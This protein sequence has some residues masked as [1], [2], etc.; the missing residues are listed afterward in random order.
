MP[1]LTW[2]TD[3]LSKE[4]HISEVDIIC[5]RMGRLKTDEGPIVSTPPAVP[6]SATARRCLESTSEEPESAPVVRRGR[7]PRKNA[8]GQD[9]EASVKAAA[10]AA[11]VKKRPV[12]GRLARPSSSTGVANPTSCCSTLTSADLA[13]IPRMSASAADCDIYCDKALGLLSPSSTLTVAKANDLT[14]ASI[15]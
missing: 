14:G 10:M 1:G 4:V 12:G 9:R 7:K 6:S 15:H 5:A 3:N 11:P 8:S 2:T 13:E